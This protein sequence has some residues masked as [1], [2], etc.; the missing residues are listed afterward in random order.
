MSRMTR[1]VVGEEID[2]VGEGF[3]LLLGLLRECHHKVD[4]IGNMKLRK[5]V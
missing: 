5:D 1:S 2:L 3:V 4:G